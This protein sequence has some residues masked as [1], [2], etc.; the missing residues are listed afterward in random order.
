MGETVIVVDTNLIHDSPMLRSR[1]WMELISK[2][3]HWGLRFV[4]PEICVREALSVV[5]RKWF[6]ER[7]GVAKLK[8]GEFDLTETQQ[9]M[10]DAID[11]KIQGYEDALRAR[12]V[13][14]SAEVVEVPDSVSWLEVTQRAIDRRAP[15]SAKKK[16]ALRD[17]LIWHTVRSVAARDN[18]CEVWLVSQNHDDFGDNSETDRD[19][20]P[21]PFHSD[22]REEL[23]SHGLSDRV[24]Y[25]R[26]LGR[27]VQHLAGRYDALPQSKQEALIERLDR[28]EFERQLADS[29][30]HFYLEPAAAA[31]PVRTDEAS[32]RSFS[33]NVESLQFIDAAMRGGAA[34]TA[35]F[36]QN[37]DATV[38]LTDF[39]GD[40]STLEKTLSVAGRLVA[41]ANGSVTDLIVTSLEAL[42]DDPMR[43]AWIRTEIAWAS[44]YLK[45]TSPLS[46]PDFAKR[47]SNAMYPWNDPGWAKRLSNL[48]HPWNDPELAKRLSNAVEQLRK[49]ETVKQ[50]DSPVDDDASTDESSPTSEGTD[51]DDETDESPDDKDSGNNAP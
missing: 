12:I 11:S 1:D 45:G 25:V 34:W 48:T 51:P 6:I 32:I 38:D 29:L 4:L 21:F 39:A 33:S 20:C 42:P 18:E 2:A 7:A 17:T 43:R 23:E 40:T 16:D 46:D 13:E 30:Q 49:P 28:P 3:A 41:G 35:Q 31:L 19:A 26:S 44:E 47:L 8:V 24:S 15:Y 10:L 37:I 27:L 50:S 22:L 9:A 36:Q 14:I 5:R